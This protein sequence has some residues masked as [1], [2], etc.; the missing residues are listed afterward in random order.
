MVRQMATTTL[1]LV[2]F[3]IP[4]VLRVSLWWYVVSCAV[5]VMEVELASDGQEGCRY[6]AYGVCGLW[7][8]RGAGGLRGA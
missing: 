4:H 7:A 1:L 6:C 2:H 8:A 5:G 3:L